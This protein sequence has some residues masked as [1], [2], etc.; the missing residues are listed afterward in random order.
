MS[1]RPCSSVN[2]PATH[3]ATYSPTLCPII[4]DGCEHNAHLYYL[5]LP[6]FGARNR[7]IAS[8]RERGIYA[9]FHYVPLHSAPAGLKF[10]RTHGSLSVTDDVASRLLR[11]GPVDVTMSLLL[12]IQTCV[13]MEH[14]TRA[15]GKLRET[16]AMACL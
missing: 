14:A 6:D 1:F 11:D 13:G 5:L 12:A 3:A 15:H 4:P 7:L 2:T 10:A 16:L 8:L 9:P